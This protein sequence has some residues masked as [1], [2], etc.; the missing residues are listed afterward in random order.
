MFTRTLIAG[1]FALAATL[2]TTSVYAVNVTKGVNKT[3][4][5]TKTVTQKTGPGGKT[6][7]VDLHKGQT[8]TLGGTVDTKFGSF[9]KTVTLSNEHDINLT[10]GPGGQKSV[11][12][13]GDNSRL[14]YRRPRFSISS[15]SAESSWPGKRT[16]STVR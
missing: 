16:C 14:R 2:M 15:R 1:T 12:V 8:I 13:S 5:Q 6:T 9:G 3:Q 7:S 4:T 10:K 11:S